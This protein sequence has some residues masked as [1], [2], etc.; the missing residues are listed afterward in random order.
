MTS[1]LASNILDWQFFIMLI[2]G[3]LQSFKIML[4]PKFL[5]T[6]V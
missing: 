5:T 1:G 3:Y 4:W 6:T 2:R